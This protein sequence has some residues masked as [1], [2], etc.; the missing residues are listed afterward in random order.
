MEHRRAPPEMSERTIGYTRIEV[1]QE[2]ITKL[3]LDAIVNTVNLR[4]LRP[5]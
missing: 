2:D 3:L 4:C 5:A 1:R